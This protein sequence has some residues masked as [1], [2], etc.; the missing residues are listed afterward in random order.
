MTLLSKSIDFPMRGSIKTLANARNTGD[1]PPIPPRSDNGLGD[2]ALFKQL[3]DP[4]FDRLFDPIFDPRIVAAIMAGF[5]PRDIPHLG[6]YPVTSAPVPTNNA[7]ASSTSIIPT[8]V[9]EPADYQAILL[10]KIKELEMEKNGLLVKKSVSLSEQMK[11]SAKSKL[12]HKQGFIDC[13]SVSCMEKLEA[14][15]DKQIDNKM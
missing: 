8:T 12:Q 15:V 14:A 13:N 7:H 1:A 11:M 3:L 10:A 2:L 9:T 6:R 5:S 4:L